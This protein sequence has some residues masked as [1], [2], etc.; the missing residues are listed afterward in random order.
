[1]TEREKKKERILKE[2]RELYSQTGERGKKL[3]CGF[4]I[5]VSRESDS[6]F[7]CPECDATMLKGTRH[8]GACGAVLDRP[9]GV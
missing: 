4:D 6:A 5:P 7:R 3:F 2:A 9:L 8:C 1:M